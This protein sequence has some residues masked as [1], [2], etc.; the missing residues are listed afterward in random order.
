MQTQPYGTDPERDLL[1]LG[2]R[3]AYA[4]DEIFAIEKRMC[5]AWGL[6]Y[7]LRL[8]YVMLAAQ[9]RGIKGDPPLL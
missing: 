1:E 6:P 3:A 7:D 9:S 5:R 2:R 8:Q 4:Y